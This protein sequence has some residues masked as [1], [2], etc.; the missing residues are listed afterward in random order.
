[1]FKNI[2][3]DDVIMIGSLLMYPKTRLRQAL[4]GCGVSH[5][6]KKKREVV[7]PGW[8]GRNYPKFGFGLFLRF[9]F[10]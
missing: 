4:V 5:I 1:M 6:Q 10:F 9:C 7:L 2:I 8:Y 3:T